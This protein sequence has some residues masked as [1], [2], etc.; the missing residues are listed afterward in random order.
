MLLEEETGLAYR[1]ARKIL[2]HYRDE[3]TSLADIY[4]NNRTGYLQHD[5][6]GREEYKS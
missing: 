3:T 1:E 4:V 2:Y 5:M 6:Q